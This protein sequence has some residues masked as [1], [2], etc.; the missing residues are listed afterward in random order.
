MLNLKYVIGFNARNQNVF[1]S[2]QQILKH[3]TNE[4]LHTMQILLLVRRKQ[5]EFID[6]IHRFYF[7]HLFSKQ[8]QIFMSDMLLKN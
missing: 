8:N 1:S 6:D 4:A 5:R 2:R 3:R 7:S